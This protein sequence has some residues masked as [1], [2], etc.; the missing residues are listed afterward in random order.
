VPRPDALHVAF[1]RP[2]VQP[3][4]LSARVAVRDHLVKEDRAARLAVVADQHPL[5]ANA[6]SAFLANATAPI[7][8]LD[9]PLLFEIGADADCDGVVVVS[10][11]PEVQRQRVLERG[12]MSEADFEL[13]LSRQMPD[14]EK[15]SRARWVIET[16]TLD[17]ARQSVANIL[18]EIQQELPNA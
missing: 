17:A 4:E 13:I 14:G 5:V 3:V 15:R 1:L 10:V 7:V 16:L 11:P 9:I 2:L 18:S 12:E 6:R 8:L